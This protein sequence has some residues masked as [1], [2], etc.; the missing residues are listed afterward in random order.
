VDRYSIERS[1]DGIRFREIGTAAPD[2]GPLYRF[3]D[4]APLAG[5]GYYRIR[6]IARD[7]ST[8]LSPAVLVQGKSVSGLQ[9]YPN[10]VRTT[11]VAQV[12]VPESASGLLLVT[13]TGGQL[14]C[15]QEVR[16]QKGNNAITLDLSA[17]PSGEYIFQVVCGKQ[18]WETKLLKVRP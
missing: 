7:G 9:L 16:L 2:G 5:T 1:S 12:T 4:A 3:A 14:V 17:L 15:R 6:E 11:V 8:S 10:P 13:G 18:R